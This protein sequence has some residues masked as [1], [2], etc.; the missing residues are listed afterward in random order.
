MEEELIL[1]LDENMS[2]P[3]LLCLDLGSFNEYFPNSALCLANKASVQLT[4]SLEGPNEK[5]SGEVLS[6][7]IQ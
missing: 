2:S 4:A 6:V 7:G 3:S 1:W 5:T